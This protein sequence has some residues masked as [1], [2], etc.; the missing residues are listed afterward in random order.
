MLS[1][2]PE[3]HFTAA[4]D[5]NHK[6]LRK[7]SNLSESHGAALKTLNRYV[8]KW[9]RLLDSAEDQTTFLMTSAL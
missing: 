5:K 6:R 3:C 2:D 1:V 4:A 9:R 8:V 7:K